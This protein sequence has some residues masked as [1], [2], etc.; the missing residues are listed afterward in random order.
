MQV[1]I[2]VV[3]DAEESTNLE[4]FRSEKK[5]EDYRKMLNENNM[6]AVIDEVK[7]DD[8]APEPEVGPPHSVR[9]N[10]S[11]RLNAKIGE[12][13]TDESMRAPAHQAQWWAESKL[14]EAF[15]DALAEFEFNDIEVLDEQGRRVQG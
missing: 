13:V 4:A 10:F 11:A 15:G 6:P 1:R 8:E 5:A 3:R 7:L 12:I 9:V 2:F 14:S